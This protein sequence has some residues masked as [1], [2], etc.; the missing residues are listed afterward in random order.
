MM[1]AMET[2]L[3]MGGFGPEAIHL[4]QKQAAGTGLEMVAAGGMGGSSAMDTKPSTAAAREVVPGSAVSAQLMRGDLEIAATCT[5]T[6]VD[7]KQL[8]A[9]GHPILQAGQVSLPMTTAEVVAT[10]ASP[11]N[12]F[13][14]VNT[15]ATIGA[16]NEDR[17]AAIRGVFGAEAR[18]I[19]VHVAVHGQGKPRNLN[20]EIVDLPSLT[21][22][23]VLVAVYQGLLQSNESTD[24][25]SYHVTGSISLDGY[26]PA[27]LDVWA[28]AG[29]GTGAPMSA[30]FATEDR[31]LRLY[32]NGSRQGAVREVNLEVEAIPRRVGVEL[33]GARLVSGDIVHAGDTVMVEA[34]LRP[35]RQPAHNVRI[36]VR[37]P[38]RLGPGN[39]RLLI[40]DAGTLDR[41]LDQPRFQTHSTGLETA[42]AAARGQHAGDRVYVSLLAPETQ[43]GMEGQTLTGLPLSMGN[44]LESRRATQ[45]A[46]LNGESVEL[47]GEAPAEGFLMGFAV[48]N[49]RI[50]AGGGLD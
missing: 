5:V 15:G 46:S 23:A 25:T 44:A 13:K 32:A 38:A 7:P 21:P 16:F 1:R 3:V 35:W 40:S 50:E 48:L 36:P 19:P 24:E 10:L 22:M 43:A 31:F 30:A 28:P 6:Y 17:D 47:A 8:L 37:I 39:L 4:W 9:C 11:L 2:P 34:T 42:I 33:V 20:V 27:P 29:E 45:D 26:P 41:T 12:A 14:I 49:L 18:M